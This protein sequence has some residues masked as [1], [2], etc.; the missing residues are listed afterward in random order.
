MKGDSYLYKI[1]FIYGNEEKM[2]L[3][4]DSKIT[5]REMLE[6]FLVATKSNIILSPS[7]ITFFCGPN[8]LN[9]PK[10]ID[11]K[12]E[13]IFK[14]GRITPIKVNDILNIIGGGGTKINMEIN[15]QFIKRKEQYFPSKDEELFGI[16]KLCLLKEISSKLDYYIIKKLNRNISWILEILK[17]GYIIY[18]T[19]EE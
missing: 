4:F 2:E 6:S 14:R 10:F 18:E 5:V 15:I 1:T 19:S 13:N 3:E 17:N 7:E 11:K 12:L 8:I 9:D 16:S